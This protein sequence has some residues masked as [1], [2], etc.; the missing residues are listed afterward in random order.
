MILH[1]FINSVREYLGLIEV[2]MCHL[3]SRFVQC[4]LDGR[5]PFA[6]GTCKILTYGN[7]FSEGTYVC[8]GCHIR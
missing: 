8:I 4:R 5:S 7:I 6:G 1:V 2:Y 3:S